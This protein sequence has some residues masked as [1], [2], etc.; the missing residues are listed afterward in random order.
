M[1]CHLEKK[2][3][4]QAWWCELVRLWRRTQLVILKVDRCQKYLHFSLKLFK[5]DFTDSSL[6]MQQ[7]L[8]EYPPF[9]QLSIKAT[10]LSHQPIDILA[11]KPYWI[12]LL[13]YGQF[14]ARQWGEWVQYETYSPTPGWPLQWN[15]GSL[16]TV[17]NLLPSLFKMPTLCLSIKGKKASY[18]CLYRT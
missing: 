8:T 18:P 11:V 5:A 10:E 15:V 7:H 16:T 2:L 1:C 9:L 4:S 13:P 3:L 12:G 14:C 6:I 17:Y